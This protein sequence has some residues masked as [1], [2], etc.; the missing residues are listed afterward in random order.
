MSSTIDE[1]LV[2][3]KVCTNFRD[4]DRL[5]SPKGFKD[6]SSYTGLCKAAH[7]GCDLCRCFMRADQ[8]Q[9]AEGLQP[10]F[11]E[12]MDASETQIAWKR[13]CRSSLFMLMQNASKTQ[14][15]LNI[16]FELYTDQAG[17]LS[18]RPI[19]TTSNSESCYDLISYWMSKC[20]IEYRFCPRSENL[21]FPSR[22]IE[23]G[24]DSRVPF[25]IVLRVKE[26]NGS[27]FT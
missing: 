21:I 26:V 8:L 22:V 2:L 7:N 20:R 5:L 3:C 4:V 27:R 11:D 24:S 23:V 14:R 9:Y 18:A 25:L 19:Q 6:H 10:N 12:D 1:S 13:Y 15:P 17:I 16:W